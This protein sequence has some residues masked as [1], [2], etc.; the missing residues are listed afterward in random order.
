MMLDDDD[1]RDDDDDN[2]DDDDV[3]DCIDGLHSSLFT[4]NLTVHNKPWNP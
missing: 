2:D 3:D 1:V 4:P